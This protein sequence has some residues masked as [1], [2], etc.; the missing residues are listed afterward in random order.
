MPPEKGRQRRR[1]VDESSLAAGVTQVFPAVTDR[2]NN[3]HLRAC[4][5]V[6]ARRGAGFMTSV[7]APV[8]R[9]LH[10]PTV[11][12]WIAFIPVVVVATLLVGPLAAQVGATM[13]GV[14]II[15]AGLQTTNWRR[16]TLVLIGV[17]LVAVAIVMWWQATTELATQ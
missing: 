9:A 8:N 17:L 16:T 3:G 1:Y 15:M 14:A 4:H 6:R 11:R 5:A 13:A 2:D 10:N 12:G 7:Q